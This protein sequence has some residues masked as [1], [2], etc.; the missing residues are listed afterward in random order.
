V[1]VILFM[2]LGKLVIWVAQTS[3]FT[4]RIW[5]LNGFL[6]ELGDCDFCTGVWVM[7]I[8]AW[9]GQVNL[10][11]PFYMPVLSEFLTGTVASFA[12]HLISIGWKTQYQI[13]EMS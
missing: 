5:K 10:L 1:N 13:I 7:W 6:Q 12:L 4:R 11:A 2:G 9:F 8:L 3:G